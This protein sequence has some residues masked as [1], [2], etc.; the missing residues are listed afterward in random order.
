MWT[1][2][3]RG[4]AAVV[5]ALAVVGLF[6]VTGAPFTVHQEMVS[7]LAAGIASQIYAESIQRRHRSSAAS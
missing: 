2:L 3:Y 4:G 5:T 6:T 1:F 7:G